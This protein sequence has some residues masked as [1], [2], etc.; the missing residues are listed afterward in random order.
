MITE[1]DL[2]EAIAECKGQRNPNASTCIKLAAFLTIQRELYGT[3]E[4]VSMP[5]FSYA[6]PM[7]EESEPTISYRG[8]TEFA[9]VIDGRRT[10]DII[11]LMDELMTTL[12][13]VYPR[14][15]DAVIRQLTE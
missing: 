6:P 4:Q 1:Q 8:D 9:R 3:A 12:Q 15:Y 2:Q 5:S 7:I 13:A 11:A 14:L 10:N